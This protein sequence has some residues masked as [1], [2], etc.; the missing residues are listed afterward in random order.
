MF[1]KE[2]DLSLKKNLF[3]KAKPL[4]K[5]GYNSLINNLT[6]IQKLVQTNT[7]ISKMNQNWNQYPAC[8]GFAPVAVAEI[9]D[10]GMKRGSCM[11]S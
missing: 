8:T 4:T 5:S 10:F 11:T 3:E 1:Y 9:K 6:K 2:S 7:N